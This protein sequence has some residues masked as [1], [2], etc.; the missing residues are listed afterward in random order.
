MQEGVE[1]KNAY[2]HNH[3]VALRSDI[4]DI[5]SYKG[6][7]SDAVKSDV[8]MDGSAVKEAKN[9]PEG[10]F[11]FELNA[12]EAV[13]SYLHNG[14]ISYTKVTALERKPLLAYPSSNPNSDY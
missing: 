10:D 9:T 14:V 7:F 3:K 1:I 12:D 4:S 2:F 6:G 8:V 11:P 5:D 13:I